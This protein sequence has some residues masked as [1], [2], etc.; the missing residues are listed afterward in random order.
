MQADMHFYGIYALA[1][2][3]GL[4]R[5]TAN[6][7]ASASEYVDDSILDES[8]HLDDGRSM[9]AEMTAHQT[10]DYHNADASDQRKVWLPFHFLP[11]GQGSTIG[12]KLI[13][14]KDSQIAREVVKRNLEQAAKVKYG[15]H[16]VGVTAHVYADTFAHYGFIGANHE[17][18]A[19]RDGTL[20]EIIDDPSVLDHVMA[21]AGKLFDRIKSSTLSHGFPLGHGPAVT[22]PDRPYL[23]WSYIR[24]VD[25]VKIER[26]N[27]KDFMEGCKAL[28]AMLEQYATNCPNHKDPAGGKRWVDIS[29]TVRE[30]IKFEGKKDDRI[31]KWKTAM[32][33]GQLSAKSETIPKY[34]GHRWTETIEKIKFRPASAPEAGTLV[35][36][37]LHLYYRAARWH[38][39]LVLTE[40]LPEHG[41]LAA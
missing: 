12:E 5:K 35:K 23:R 36:T 34:L 41:I 21:Q 38:R 39:N 28:H 40:L 17:L 26:D 32:T 1:R 37:D 14:R 3:A 25:G 13:C 8:I 4:K 9:L 2:A 22:Y 31:Q 33:S 16:L 15:P 7:I 27:S 29:S 11:G 10:I 6:L 24:E 18:N 30:I 20:S 19:I